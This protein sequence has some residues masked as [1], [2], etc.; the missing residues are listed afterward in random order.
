M[1]RKNDQDDCTPV[2]SSLLMHVTYTIQNTDQ[3][4][5]RKVYPNLGM[6]DS[7]ALDTNFSAL[8]PKY[9]NAKS[10]SSRSA[11]IVEFS[12]DHSTMET[13][14]YPCYGSKDME[15]C[16]AN[17]NRQFKQLNRL[18]ED[19]ALSGPHLESIL[20]NSLLDTF[21]HLFDKKIQS[22]IVLDFDSL[23][24][25]NFKHF[26]LNTFYKTTF[27]VQSNFVDLTPELM[28]DTLDKKCIKNTA[29]SD[30][31][32]KDLCAVEN[33]GLFTLTD[34]DLEDFD[35][36]ER[37]VPICNTERNFCYSNRKN[38]PDYDFYKDRVAY[39]C[40]CKPGWK[41]VA[42][43]ELGP[44]LSFLNHTCK[45]IDECADPE[46]N[47]CDQ[48][49]TICENLPGSYRCNCEKN[50]RPENGTHCIRK[51]LFL[52]FSLTFEF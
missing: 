38:E 24:G 48:E 9:L 11:D 40:R 25:T 16:V 28:R 26:G 2:K 17:W 39:E 35:V 20:R 5:K 52:N 12:K 37:E 36:C 10:R 23:T 32:S 50:Y 29:D 31:G 47:K 43:N 49:S 14:Q 19:L 51:K 7:V 21:N 6:I 34:L 18:A 45:D 33:L 1:W 3:N 15:G 44:F 22:I 13:V 27:L 4:Q 46:L 42:H 30:D 41:S 8:I